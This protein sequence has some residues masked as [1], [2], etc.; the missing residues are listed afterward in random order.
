MRPIVPAHD[1][2]A[3]DHVATARTAC[4]ERPTQTIQRSMTDFALDVG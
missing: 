1:P 2:A 3:A 4:R